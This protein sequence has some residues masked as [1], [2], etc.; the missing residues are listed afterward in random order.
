[1]D[2]LVWAAAAKA[3]IVARD[4]TRMRKSAAD[5][6]ESLGFE[7]EDQALVLARK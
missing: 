7:A 3:V 2:S 5:E 4:R 1:M 6:D